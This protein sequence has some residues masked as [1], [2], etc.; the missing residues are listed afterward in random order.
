MVWSWIASIAQ[1]DFKMQQLEQDRRKFE[2]ELERLNREERKR[3]NR[4]MIF[5]GVAAL[6]FAIVEIYATLA[7]INPEHWL[8]NWLR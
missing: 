8:F 6:I 2:L 1:E 7:S 3:T 5:L 4:I